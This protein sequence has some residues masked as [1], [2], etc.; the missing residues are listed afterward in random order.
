VILQFV[1]KYKSSTSFKN[2]KYPELDHATRKEVHRELHMYR[3]V[4][5][6]WLITDNVVDLTDDVQVG[7]SRRVEPLTE[8]T[9]VQTWMARSAASSHNRCV[10]RSQA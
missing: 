10:A 1:Q 6:Q 7:R 4:L 5:C 2:A 8:L 9:T 3:S